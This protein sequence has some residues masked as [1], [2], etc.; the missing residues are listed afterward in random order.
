MVQELTTQPS[1]FGR[2]GKGLSRGLSETVPKEIE[3]QR[4]KSGLQ[5]LANDYDEGNLSQA[6]FL[7]RAAGTYGATPQIIQSFGELAKQQN[8]AN[9]YGRNQTYG[10]QQPK[11]SADLRKFQEENLLQNATKQNISNQAQVEN[12]KQTKNIA[13]RPV[14]PKEKTEEIVNENPLNPSAFTRLPWSPQQR[15]DRVRDYLNQGFL[16]DQA[17]ELASDDESRDLA[18]PGALQKRQEEL[19]KKSEE[20]RSEFRRQ[21]ETK[22]QKS[23]EGVFKDVTGEMLVNMERGL[24]RDLRSKPGSSFKEVANDW[25]RRALEVAKAKNG[26]DKLSSSTGSEAIFKGDEIL[27]QLNEYS[28][29]FKKSGNSEEYYNL[30]QEKMRLSPKGAA[31]VAYPRTKNVKDYIGKFKPSTIDEAFKR[32]QKARKTAIDLENVLT[33]EDSLLAIARD[34]KNKDEF[35]DESSFFDQLSEDKDKISLNDQQRRE[36]TERKGD[37]IPSWGDIFILPWFGR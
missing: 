14:N 2:L 24:E 13:T 22:L 10:T 9:A 35:F 18:E 16:V 20:A 30:L 31:S 17:K 26:F 23:G 4:L 19:T 5:S 36:L 7:A 29:I 21:L 34:L 37:I 27:K 25:S 8:Q 3:H 1:I 33:N 6:Q 12:E 32:D 28:D 11:A 15:N